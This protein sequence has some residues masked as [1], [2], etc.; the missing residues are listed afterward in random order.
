MDILFCSA[1]GTFSDR[2]TLAPAILKACVESAGF[3]STAIDLNIEIYNLIQQHPRRV[4]IEDFFKQ[5]KIHSDIVDDIGDLIDYCTNRIIDLNPPILGLSLLTQD[6]QFFAVWLCFH[7]KAVKPDLK[8]IIGGSGIKTFVAES[9]IN[10][11]DLLESKGYIDDYINGD[12]E[13]TIVEYLRG[14]LSYPGIN[15]G[16]WQP[17]KDLNVLPW[18]N[19]SDYDF[20]QYRDPGIPLCDSRGCVR[21]CEFCDIIEHWKK[22][23]Y[24]TADNIFAEMQYQINNYGLKKFFFYNSLTNGN[25]KEFLRLLDLI[26]DYNDQNITDQISWDGYF[27]VRNAKQHPEEFW[28]KINKSNGYLQLGIESVVEKVRIS[29][30]KNFTNQDIDYHLEMAKKYSVPLLL[31]LIVGYPTETRED[32]EFT[33][34][35]FQDRAQYANDPIN[36]VVLSMSAILPNTQ[37]ERKQQDYGIIRGEI[38]TVWMTQISA[39]STKDRLK[40]YNELNELLILLNMCP[41]NGGDNNIDSIENELML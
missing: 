31:L 1:P 22:Y 6:S 12:G 35:W 20:S 34:Q 24:R 25:M 33:K 15:S 32:F 2:P 11:A 14:N 16:S 7:I 19:F 5:Q 4:L 40:H 39:I 29:L 17:I 27:I 26:C 13:Y 18:A 10:F 38:P 21:T 28:Q 36:S 23:Q 30:G 3:S 9:T 37:L 41:S 8:I